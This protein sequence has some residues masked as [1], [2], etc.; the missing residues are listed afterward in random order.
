MVSGE[1]LFLVGG[2][3]VPKSVWAV[4]VFGFAIV[5]GLKILL[6][7]SYLRVLGTFMSQFRG[8]SFETLVF[9]TGICLPFIFTIGISVLIFSLFSGYE[10]HRREKRSAEYARYR[11]THKLPDAKKGKKR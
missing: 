10:L 9:L 7:E 6:S 3:M 2:N 8:D 5:G 4:F 1:V 11:Y